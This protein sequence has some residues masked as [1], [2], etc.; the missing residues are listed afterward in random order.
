M[1]LPILRFHPLLKSVVWGGRKLVSLLNKHATS[2]DPLGES[3]ELCDLE[4][5]QSVV[6]TPNSLAGS[7]LHDLIAAYGD[8]FIPE[9][10]LMDGRFPLLFKFIDAKTM[11]SV[12]VH[13]NEQT[14]VRIGGGARAKNEAWYIVDCE[15]DSFI[16]SGLNPGV[17]RDIFENAV[18]NNTVERLLRRIEVRPGEFYNIPAGEVHA[19]GGGVILAEVQQSSDTTYRVYDYGRIDG[20][21]GKLRELHQAEA[22]ESIH[23]GARLQL[24]PSPTGHPGIVTP[25]FHMFLFDMFAGAAERIASKGAV[26]F[27][28][29]GKMGEASIVAGNSD[30][31]LRLGDTLLV[32]ACIS[33]D[34]H[35]VASS[36]IQILVTKVP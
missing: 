17:T 13:P 18:A 32:P 5:F 3:W 21:T 8:D 35:I 28:G 24:S 29:V 22:V 30:E 12:Q 31:T 4:E 15:P 20:A 33:S 14:A 2:S 16:Y 27:M 11:L 1:T 26:A 34:I 25:Y 36:D 9:R 6:R 10:S 23:F 7:S 19:I